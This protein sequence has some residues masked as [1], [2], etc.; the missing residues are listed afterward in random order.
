MGLY[1]LMNSQYSSNMHANKQLVNTENWSLKVFSYYDNIMTLH[2][3]KVVY[4]THCFV[5]AERQP[6]LIW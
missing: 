2:K 3:T 4:N 1:V 6:I 5:K